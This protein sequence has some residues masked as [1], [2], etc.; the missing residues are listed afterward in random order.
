MTQKWTPISWENKVAL[1]QPN[2]KDKTKL[3]NVIKKLKKFPPLVFAGEVRDLKENFQNVSTEKVFYC[4]QE[5][6]QR[7]LQNFIQIILEIHLELFYR[8]R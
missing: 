8:C 1:H 6:V 4:K 2:Y 7:V 3:S 5:I